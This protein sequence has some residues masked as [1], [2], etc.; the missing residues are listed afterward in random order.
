MILSAPV[1]TTSIPEE[2]RYEKYKE[3]IDGYTLSRIIWE[4]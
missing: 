2:D 1:T 4:F 3:Y